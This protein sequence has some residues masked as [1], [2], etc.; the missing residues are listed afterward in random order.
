MLADEMKKTRKNR[1]E[2]TDIDQN[3]FAELL[4]FFY[5][6]QFSKQLASDLS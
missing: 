4:R 2:V 1:V 3:V 5:T 6:N